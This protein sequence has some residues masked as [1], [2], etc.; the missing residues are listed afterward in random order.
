MVSLFFSLP[1]DG[2]QRLPDESAPVKSLRV[3]AIGNSF[4]QDAT[5]Q[6]LSEL[7]MAAGYSIIVG[8]CYI[9][10]CTLERHWNNESS[11]DENTR[12]SNTYYKYVQ[13]VKTTT[14]KVSIAT[15]LQDEPWDYV[16]LGQGA[17]LYGIVDSHYP[18]LDNF[19]TYFTISICI[20]LS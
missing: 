4:T 1:C 7:F 17:G 5:D 12:N 13:G 16:I 11:T 6:Y 15:I 18:Y 10:G 20:S 14:S 3:L 9:G 2:Q 8:N 19:L